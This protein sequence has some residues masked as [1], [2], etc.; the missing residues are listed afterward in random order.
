MEARVKTKGI[1][2]KDDEVVL[3]IEVSCA[4]FEDSVK[5]RD[6]IRQ[7]LEHDLKGQARLT[8]IHIKKE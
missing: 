8:A 5:I 1:I 3:K 6:Y 7:N 4:K 2:E